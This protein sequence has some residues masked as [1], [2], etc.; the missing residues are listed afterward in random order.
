MRLLWLGLAIIPLLL[1]VACGGGSSATPTPKD[2]GAAALEG[3]HIVDP[4]PSLPNGAVPL[5]YYYVFDS[6]PSLATPLLTLSIITPLPAGDK[7]TWYTYTNNQWTAVM[8][9]FPGGGNDPTVQ[10]TFSPRPDNIVV[11]AE[12]Q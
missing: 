2:V 3:A 11:L 5:T 8:Q 10:A 1:L 6:T 12:P 7:A 9:A 4:P